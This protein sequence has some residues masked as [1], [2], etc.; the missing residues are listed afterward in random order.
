M[1][2]HACHGIEAYDTDIPETPVKMISEIADMTIC[3]PRLKYGLKLA[4]CFF[5]YNVPK[6]QDQ[7]AMNDNI[8]PNRKSLLRKS[9]R[10]S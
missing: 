9:C 3:K 10:C 8:I 2:A 1:A 7:V 4:A 5:V 6:A